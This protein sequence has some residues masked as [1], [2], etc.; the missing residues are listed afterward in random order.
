[1]AKKKKSFPSWKNTHFLLQDF[2]GKTETKLLYYVYTS[3]LF[4]D[5]WI[6][7]PFSLFHLVH[8][9]CRVYVYTCTNIHVY[10][11][12]IMLKK[13]KR[14][15]PSQLFSFIKSFSPPNNSRYKLIHFRWLWSFHCA[16]AVYLH[17]YRLERIVRF[18]RANV[19]R[20]YIYIYI[21]MLFMYLL[22]AQI[23]LLSLSLFQAEREK[24]TPNLWQ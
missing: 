21:Y 16:Y 17:E 7:L 8:C 9:T 10:V 18:F 19:K 1:M 3:F 11:C 4:H 15:L 23:L 24:I 5:K 12:M 14:Y 6:S 20:L 13:M 22:A 2:R